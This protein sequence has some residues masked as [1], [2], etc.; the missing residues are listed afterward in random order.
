MSCSLLQKSGLEPA[1]IDRLKLAYRSVPGLTEMDAFT[2][3][4][5]A[6]GILARA[7]DPERARALQVSLAAQGIES[8]LVEDADLPV[9]PEMRSVHKLDPT[10]DALMICDPL[11]QSFPL[12]WKNVLLIAAGRTHLVEFNPLE[13]PRVAD[14]GRG[15]HFSIVYDRET[16]EEHNDRWMLDVVITGGALRYNAVAQQP[17]GMLFQYLGARMT[18]DLADNFKLLVQ[19][20]IRNAPEAGINRG[21]Y[22]LR[23]NSE[24]TFNYPNRTSFYNEMLWLLW[25]M[26]S[27]AS[28]GV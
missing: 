21:A 8:E 3:G 5:D 20:L 7:F 4:R 6:F 27:A 14:L 11:G 9:L 12:P 25:K 26:K 28:A 17:G 15:H 23:E 24:K 2:L 19:D 10:P 16:H 22:Y 13:V 1:S 18:D